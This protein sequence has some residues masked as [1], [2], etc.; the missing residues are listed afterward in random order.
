MTDLGALPTPAQARE[1]GLPNQAIKVLQIHERL[2]AFERME[3]DKQKAILRDRLDNLLNHAKRYSPFWRERLSSWSPKEKWLEA[4][5][6]KVP[7]LSR[8]DLQSQ[9]GQIVAKFPQRSKMRISKLSTSGSTGTPVSIEHLIDLHNPP[10]HA[11]TLLTG[12]WHNIDPQK[13]LGAVRPSIEDMERTTLGIPFNWLGASETGFTRNTEGREDGELY[14]YCSAKKPT[15]L[16][17]GALTLFR[18]ARYAIRNNRQEW[19]PE[20][21]LS[22]GSVVSDEIR[23]IVTEGL[24]AKIIDRYSAEETGIIAVQCPKHDHYHVLSPI[25]LVEIVDEDGAP[26]AVGQPGRILVTGMNSFGMPLIRYDIGD[27]AE[28]GED[29]D[30]GIKLPVIKKLW[31]RQRHFVTHPDGRRTFVKMFLNR[32][33]QDSWNLEEYRFVL[34]QGAMIVAQLKV[35][36]PSPGLAESVTQLVHNAVGYPYPVRIEIVDEID[37][38]LSMKKEGFAVSDAPAPAQTPHEEAAAFFSLDMS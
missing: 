19:R 10:Q 5:L 17:A 35:N 23:E 32:D 33:F 3:P 34:H 28:W 30:C 4:S 14:D 24:G 12:R 27:I 20:C 36:G 38:G 26:C 37:W 25:T 31:G 11:A 21:A 15:Y 22:F 16:L 8:N 29:C 9:A 6:G 7:V 13:P 1:Q 18:L 2:Q